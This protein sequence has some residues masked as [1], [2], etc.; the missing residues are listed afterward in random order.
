M[1]DTQILQGRNPQDNQLF[2]FLGENQD[3]QIKVITVIGSSG[4]GKSFFLNYLL[5]DIEQF[6]N[7]RNIFPPSESSQIEFCGVKYYLSKEKFLLFLEFEGI[8]YSKNN[9]QMNDLKNCLKDC[10]DASTCIFYVHQNS[11][12]NKGFEQI[13]TLLNI[14]KQRDDH[15]VEILN[16]W[17]GDA[18]Q[19]YSQSND[20]K[21]VFRDVYYL[22]A[23]NFEDKYVLKNKNFQQFLDKMKEINKLI[24]DFSPKNNMSCGQVD[25]QI[26]QK[27][28][29]NNVQFLNMNE[30]ANK[31]EPQAESENKFQLQTIQKCILLIPYTLAFIIFTKSI[32]RNQ[33]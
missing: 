14:Q 32:Q 22:K 12:T 1:S 8:D 26:F 24:N 9:E 5:Q 30:N 15:L 2:T 10:A 19:S 31:K 29:Q 20:Y 16:K 21:D 27:F 33:F 4:V 7:M 23:L 25:Q 28:R 13:L 17:N 18:I 6:N 3:K 11:R